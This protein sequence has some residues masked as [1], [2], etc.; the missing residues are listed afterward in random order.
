[1]A[2][3]NPGKKAFVLVSLTVKVAIKARLFIAILLTSGSTSLASMVI[4]S[5][6]SCASSSSTSTSSYA[7]MSLPYSLAGV[8]MVLVVVEEEVCGVE[9]K[10]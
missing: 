9:K 4:S 10:E 1:M 2:G 3:R 8:V 5:G 7:P 6:D